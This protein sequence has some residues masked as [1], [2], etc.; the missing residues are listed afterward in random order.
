MVFKNGKKILIHK[1][2]DKRNNFNKIVSKY[3][4][5][6]RTKKEK[7]PEY[8]FD[9]IIKNVNA[10]KEE[11][12]WDN[13]NKY[14]SGNNDTISS[15][16]KKDWVSATS[17]K[18]YLLKDPIID[19]LDLYYSN[20]GF[21]NGS[22]GQKN[23][24]LISNKK[25]KFESFQENNKL[26][27][28]FDMGNKFEITIIDYLKKKF[29]NEIKKCVTDIN[30]LNGD[31]NKITLNYMLEGIPIIE[32]AALFNF[33]NKT[34]GVAD[35]L[36][37][38]DWIDKIFDESSMCEDIHLKAPN[39]NGDYHYKVIDIKWTTMHLCNN[40]KTIRN[41]YR[42]PAYKGQLAIYNAALGVLQGYTPKE[43]YILS[44]SWNANNGLNESHNCFSLLGSIDF[45]GFDKI[46]IKET[47]EAIR[48]IRNVRFNGMN[49]ECITPTVPELYPN[50]NNRYDTPF[51]NIKKDLAEKIKELTE[52]WMVSTKNRKIAHSKGIYS[53]NNPACSSKNMGIFGKKIGPIVDKI[54][55]INRSQSE[56]I[57][58]KKIKNNSNNWQEKKELDF[59][60]DFETIS[61]CLYYQDINLM[62]CKKDSQ[63]IFL[64]GVGYEENNVWKYK[65]F[66]TNSID[67][68]EENKI[69]TD[70][71]NFIKQKIDEFEINNSNGNFYGPRFFH[72]SNAE[73]SIFKIINER[74]NNK[75][76]LWQNKITWI[77]M[78]KIFIEEPIVIKGAKKFNLKDIAK[79]MASHKMINSNWD[80]SGP[81]DGFS[82]MIEAINHY[83]SNQVQAE[84]F[85]SIINYNEIDCKVIWEIVNYLRNN[86]I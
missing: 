58:P 40:K 26:N 77:D 55:S 42:F 4:L 86:H 20:N 68:S 63:I 43:A 1:K 66:T 9:K 44:K 69:V 67:L 52:I 36:I 53:W 50:M 81:E 73:K 21:K 5:R 34:F 18:N 23:N 25:A 28:L 22:K 6:S 41:S 49:W 14:V 32:Q 60:V 76:Y 79:T 33:K 82:A 19:W 46:Y 29:P 48:W 47:F 51:H 75:W 45:D 24:K 57:N 78:C 38:S 64:I 85:N 80:S 11:F 72:W 17:V 54:L 35:L 27:I 65:S 71:L 74:H 8:E 56:L 30:F 61:G 12:T 84:L 15:N 39:L 2:I 37:R 59:Y 62:N 83:K 7:V 16:D 31:M 70:F 10:K 13:F 3:N